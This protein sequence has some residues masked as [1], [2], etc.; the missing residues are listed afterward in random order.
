[1]WR[2]WLAPAAMLLG[3]ASAACVAPMKGIE[4]TLTAAA[5]RTPTPAPAFT[6]TPP[7]VGTPVPYATADLHLSAAPTVADPVCPNPYLD[8]DLPSPEPTTPTPE[9]T[10]ALSPAAASATP[11]PAPTPVRV[12]PVA[13]VP[14]L[15]PFA[16]QPLVRDPDLESRLS[17]VLG[18]DGA[19]FAVFAKRL[20][21]GR[22]AAVNANAVFYAAS[23]FKVSVMYEA[24]RQR[25][26]GLLDFAEQYRITDYY[27]GFNA[28]PALLAACE[29]TSI[30]D[31]ISAMMSISDN[32][33]A[34][35]LSDRVG[36][37]N[38]NADF[39]AM[40]MESTRIAEDMPV[41]A[42]DMGVLLEA[43]FRAHGVTQQ[44]ARDMLALMGTESLSDRIP[45]RLPP[46][47]GVAH[48][49]GNYSNATNDVG[50]VFAPSGPYI[51][52]LLSAWGWDRDAAEIEAELSRIV[53]DYFESG[54]RVGTP[55]SPR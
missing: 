10:A 40:G 28:G 22:G 9:A 6:A 14:A 35:F 39:A 24:F 18:A 48:K 41:T 12:G 52:V 23:T 55:T 45:A 4:P 13:P 2:S 42:A 34:V 20:S 36:S 47:T 50:I 25:S 49:T 43:I 33:A 8:R 17:E 30:G 3:L 29:V 31:A 38:I 53:Y 27:A 37:R 51:V 11:R 32:I 54:G 44:D 7:P 46:G 16:P 1:M 19:S 26:L 21:D 5:V 15:A